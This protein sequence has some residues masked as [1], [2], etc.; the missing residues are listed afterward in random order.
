M[1]LLP[2]QTDLFTCSADQ[3]ST[4]DWVSCARVQ[5]LYHSAVGFEEDDPEPSSLLTSKHTTSLWSAYRWHP[6][7]ISQGDMN[8]FIFAYRQSTQK[9]SFLRKTNPS[10]GAEDGVCVRA[11][12]AGHFPPMQGASGAHWDLR[13]PMTAMD[14]STVACADSASFSASLS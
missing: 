6:E 5:Q 2:S 1:D 8:T 14:D 13:A 4:D 7:V 3:L 11:V 10:C 9:W 12:K